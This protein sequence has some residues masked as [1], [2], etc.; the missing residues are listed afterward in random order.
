MFV[1]YSYSTEKEYHLPE[2]SK[3]VLLKT[4]PFSIK[5]KISSLAY[6][7]NLS[8][9]WCIHLMISV[10]HLKQANGL[11][12]SFWFASSLPVLV[13]DREEYE[14]AKLIDEHS[15]RDNQEYK[16]K[17]KEYKSQFNKFTWE[18]ASA[19]EKDISKLVRQYH[20]TKCWHE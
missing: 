13:N 6:E 18:P 19:I 8:T 17:W 12:E 16:V 11:I 20:N 4:G 10:V 7:I 14:I 2:L 3:L 1:K 9:G 5:W 15:S